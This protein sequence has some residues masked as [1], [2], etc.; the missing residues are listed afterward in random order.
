MHDLFDFPEKPGLPLV[1][2]HTS[3]NKALFV[4]PLREMSVLTVSQNVSHLSAYTSQKVKQ[5]VWKVLTLRGVG[6]FCILIYANV[7]VI[8]WNQ[9]IRIRAANRF[10]HSSTQNV[11]GQKLFQLEFGKS[12]QESTLATL[13]PMVI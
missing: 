2:P 5:S 3:S 12:R 8:N 4:C 9:C 1:S 10:Y 7:D 13:N 11:W 6:L